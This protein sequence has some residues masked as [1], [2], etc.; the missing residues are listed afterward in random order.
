MIKIRI[1]FEINSRPVFASPILSIINSS[2]ADNNKKA[3]FRSQNFDELRWHVFEGE[4]KLNQ[5]LIQSMEH[6]ENEQQQ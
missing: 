2:D 6:V 4:N 5:I 1:Q 3:S